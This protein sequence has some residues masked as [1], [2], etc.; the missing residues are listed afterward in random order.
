MRSVADGARCLL[1]GMAL[2]ELAEDGE[3]SSGESPVA[4][5]EPDRDRYFTSATMENTL[6]TLRKKRTK[7]AE[8]ARETAREAAQK[9]TR[10]R[11][12]VI[13]GSSSKRV[14]D[15]VQEEPVIRL[16]DK[17]SFTLGVASVVVIEAVLLRCPE[18]FG[19]LMLLFSAP[20]L[21][22]R[23]YLYLQTNLQFFLID[24]CYLV[25][26]ACLLLVVYP[27]WWLNSFCFVAA[28]GVRCNRP[29]QPHV[30]QPIHHHN[31]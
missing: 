7:L 18:K 21:V 2:Q 4:E 31:A 10:L 27:S 15:F 19:L 14:R 29:R 28:T 17:I 30:P 8:S 24:F 3:G 5:P 6:E 16:K 20:L 1:D 22:L 9:A 12:R 13:T 23:F 25:N 26:F 11:R